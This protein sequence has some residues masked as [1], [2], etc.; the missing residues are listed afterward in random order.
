MFKVSR[1]LVQLRLFY[2][3]NLDQ[4]KTSWQ[5][6]VL[7]NGQFNFWKLPYDWK[8]FLL[9]SGMKDFIQIITALFADILKYVTGN[10]FKR[11]NS[12][13]NVLIYLTVSKNAQL[14]WVVWILCFDFFVRLGNYAEHTKSKRRCNNA[15]Q[16][17]RLNAGVKK[18]FLR[19]INLSFA[20][21]FV[22]NV[23]CHSFTR[24]YFI[25]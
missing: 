25:Q 9:F 23:R 1:L 17:S 8:L 14:F 12:S 13:W 6:L 5:V 15:L 7:R 20:H 3:R 4:Y 10:Q 24:H 21:N 11:S 2:P 16:G 22:C 18:L 19:W